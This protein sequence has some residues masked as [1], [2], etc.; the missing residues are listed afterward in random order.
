LLEQL[1]ELKK[2]KARRLEKLKADIKRNILSSTENENCH[3]S[4]FQSIQNTTLLHCSEKKLEKS[5]SKTNCCNSTGSTHKCIQGTTIHTTE[6][7]PQIESNNSHFKFESESTMVSENLVSHKNS[8]SKV[9]LENKNNTYTP[10]VTDIFSD[11]SDCDEVL[12]Q[13]IKVLQYSILLNRTLNSFEEKEQNM[14]KRSTSECNESTESR[15]NKKKLKMSENV[16]HDNVSDVLIEKNIESGQSKGS[17]NEEC[18]VSTENY[19]EDSLSHNMTCF[20]SSDFLDIENDEKVQDNFKKYVDSEFFLKSHDSHNVNAQNMVS[21]VN[22]MDSMLSSLSPIN[23]NDCKVSDD[24]P[25]NVA[26]SHCSSKKSYKTVQKFKRN[27]DNCPETD[28]V[29]GNNELVKTS[30]PR[31]SSC[32]I[33]ENSPF[34]VEKSGYASE[35]FIDTHNES[36]TI[37]NV[38]SNNLKCDS[39]NAVKEDNM[40]HSC[41]LE[42]N[43]S[44]PSVSK[45]CRSLDY[46]DFAIAAQCESEEVDEN[47]TPSLLDP[48][49]VK[50]YQMGMKNEDSSIVP[51]VTSLNSIIV[52]EDIIDPDALTADID[53]NSSMSLEN[54]E[55]HSVVKGNAEVCIP[56]SE[57]F[58]IPETVLFDSSYGNK[59]VTL[60]EKVCINNKQNCGN[61]KNNSIQN[62]DSCVLTEYKETSSTEIPTSIQKKFISVEDSLNIC[63]TIYI[64]KYSKS[65]INILPDEVFSET[66]YGTSNQ[67]HTI[68]ET[69]LLESENTEELSDLKEFPISE[70]V[71]VES[72]SSRQYKCSDDFQSNI[73]LIYSFHSNIGE[74]VKDIKLVYFNHSNYAFIQHIT[75]IQAWRQEKN[76]VWTKIFS[77]KVGEVC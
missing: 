55:S 34:E 17:S 59:I 53:F 65:S 1:E 31:G 21:V 70:G 2:K 7:I 77:H 50:S 26:D 16:P 19:M 67:L 38:T 28:L 15:D 41:A 18:Q 74:A 57:I 44:L 35:K 8:D 45:N 22:C 46:H 71:C 30:K 39:A 6:N 24:S 37:K 51:E 73:E 58:T 61:D 52:D 11:N 14:R 27:N 63:E 3:D 48:V 72:N 76:K 4:P 54:T 75:W 69:I 60:K 36:S 13:N 62:I 64:Q 56:D 42:M 49:T 9:F 68:Q 23:Q 29:L 12:N 40:S 32:Y 25:E 43:S 5:S 10:A 20:L 66:L 33:L 47:R